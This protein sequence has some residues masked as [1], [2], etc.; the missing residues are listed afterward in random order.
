MFF[1]NRGR[2]F[3]YCSCY[4]LYFEYNNIIEL[5]FNIG[6]TVIKDPFLRSQ[7]ENYYTYGTEF[8]KLSV[9]GTQ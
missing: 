5:N 7:L 1:R 2:V 3:I 4:E 9:F 8:T 6:L